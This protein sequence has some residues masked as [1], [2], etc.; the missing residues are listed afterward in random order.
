MN[1]GIGEKNALFDF[2]SRWKKKLREFQDRGFPREKKK[3]KCV[4]MRYG[5]TSNL[6]LNQ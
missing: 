1:N 2:S 4:T 3:Q 5:I 6:Q